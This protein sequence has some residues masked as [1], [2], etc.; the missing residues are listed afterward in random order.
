VAVPT[1]QNKA[2][3]RAAKRRQ[4]EEELRLERAVAI[5]DPAM[6]KTPP[7]A[8]SVNEFK[9]ATGASHATV[10]RWVRDGVIKSVKVGRRRFIPFAEITRIRGGEE[11]RSAPMRFARPRVARLRVPG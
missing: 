6:A 7:A 2:R 5:A 9:R 8:V 11:P 3:K 4:R 10:S 1:D